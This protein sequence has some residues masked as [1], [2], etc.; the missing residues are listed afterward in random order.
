M[1]G[2]LENVL[3]PWSQY[4]FCVAAINIL[5]CG[6]PSAPSPIY[7]TPPDIPRKAPS[8][9]GGGGGKI[10]DLTISWTVS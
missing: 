10:G 6:F 8:N 4:E 2:T 1:E 5:G 9:V 3:L 7:N